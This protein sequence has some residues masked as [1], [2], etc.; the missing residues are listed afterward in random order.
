MI[1]EL[2]QELRSYPAHYV[3][4]HRAADALAEVES[5]RE[6]IAEQQLDIIT[7]G[8]EVGRLR[9][10]LLAT[11]STTVHLC[12]ALDV[13]MEETF[14]RVKNSKSGDV[15]A[16][17]SVADIVQAGC[18]ILGEEEKGCPTNTIK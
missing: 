5:L 15:L 8:Q 1:N 7:L 16:K 14:I 18:D 11:L 9:E 10:A 4:A 13:D 12:D 2:L 17:R 6:H 3:A